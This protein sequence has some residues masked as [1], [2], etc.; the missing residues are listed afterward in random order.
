MLNG[1]VHHEFMIPRSIGF[2][3][4]PNVFVIANK[5]F[6]RHMFDAHSQLLLPIYRGAGE[7]AHGI[8]VHGV[9]PKGDFL[10]PITGAALESTLL[11]ASF[12][13][14]NSSQSHPVFADG[15]HRSF[16]NGT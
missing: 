11:K 9:Y 16:S 2:D 5:P 10:G 15:I 7:Q 12:A 4:L 13:P 1:W 14:R 8:C 6:V 3:L